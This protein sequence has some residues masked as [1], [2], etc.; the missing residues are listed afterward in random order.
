MGLENL[1]SMAVNPRYSTAYSFMFC[2]TAILCVLHQSDP[3]HI[4]TFTAKWFVGPFLLHFVPIAAPHSN[5]N[6]IH[7]NGLYVLSYF[8]LYQ[9]QH[10]T[11]ITPCFTLSLLQ[12]TEVLSMCNT[13]FTSWYVGAKLAGGW[14]WYTSRHPREM[15]PLHFRQTA[16]KNLQTKTQDI[17]VKPVLRN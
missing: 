17:S 13:T 12:Q 11:A 1:L 5:H 6:L 7:T 4:V 8:I 9:S 10:H 2:S 14:W 16:A 15:L 3:T